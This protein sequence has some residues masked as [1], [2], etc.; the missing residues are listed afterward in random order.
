MT[1]N[2]FNLD[3]E[4]FQLL[5]LEMAQQ[6]SVDELLQLVTS[7]LASNCNVAL[8]RVWMITPGDICNTCNEYAACQ[9][10]SR[11]LHLMASCGLSIDNITNWNTIEHGA[12][13]RFPMGVRK[14]GRIASSG[15]P[16]NISAISGNSDWIADKAW[17]KKEHI[18][19]FVGQPL[20][21]KGEVLGVLAMFTRIALNQGALGLMR[22]IADHLAYAVSNARAFAEIK[23]LKRQIENENAYLR[24][25]VNIAQ[26]FNG[27][28]GKSNALHEILR[29]IVLVAPVDTS[30][31][32]TGESGTGKEL[33]AREIHSRSKRVGHPMIKINCAAIPKNLFE[34]EFFGH[35]R[36]AF[37]GAHKDREGFF[38][39]ADRGTLFLDEVSEIP[40]ELQG[41]LLRVLQE[42]EYQRVGEEKVRKVDVRIISATNRDLGREVTAG[43]FREDL[44]YRVSVFPF[45]LPPLRDRKDDIPLLVN[46][47]LV[48][49]SRRLNRPKPRLTQSDIELLTKYDWP[50][51]IR[52]L[53]NVIE[54]AVITSHLGKLDSGISSIAHLG[55]SATAPS[56]HTKDHI[57]KRG[58]LTD[59]EI[60]Q[61]ERE[62]MIKALRV[63]NGKIYGPRSASEKLRIKPTT[64]ISRLKKMGITLDDW[65]GRN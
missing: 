1:Q 6:R 47:F 58:I 3:F 54:R 9:D 28:I 17:V 57:D 20:I 39:I 21:Y 12:F 4:S 22:M 27:I 5:L 46:H 26:S 31:L 11:C 52:E 42:G 56:V 36:G 15:Q 51:N 23:R 8:A 55:V 34:S 49:T 19:S 37:T 50:G 18:A 25:E 61:L 2:N 13:R 10:K 65:H 7:S 43:R 63:C 41:K 40:L 53:Q 14:V 33:I 35:A 60:R 24:E 45:L 29:Q 30:V 62:N 48:L 44:Y 32:I 59:A 64:L 38:Q 16:G